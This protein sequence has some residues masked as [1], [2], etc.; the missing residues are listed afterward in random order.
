MEEMPSL[1]TPVQRIKVA[2]LPLDIPCSGPVIHSGEILTTVKSHRKKLNRL[3]LNADMVMMKRY[4]D[5]N[6]QLGMLEG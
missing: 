3:F 1:I 2:T 6:M 5:L 4:H